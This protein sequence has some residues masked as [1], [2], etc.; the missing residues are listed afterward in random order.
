MS[1]QLVTQL[2]CGKSCEKYYVV[3]ILYFKSWPILLL[4]FFIFLFFVDDN[5]LH[6]Y[7][8]GIGA[9]AQNLNGYWSNEPSTM[10][11]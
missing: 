9:Q 6:M 3:K 1:S 8:H 7:G 2:S 5:I 10:N 4:L 11:L